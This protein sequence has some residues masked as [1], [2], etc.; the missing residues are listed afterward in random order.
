MAYL[1]V[2]FKFYYHLYY[3]YVFFSIQHDKF[4]VETMLKGKY[5]IRR[6]IEELQAKEYSAT[7]KETSIIVTLNKDLTL[8]PMATKL[9]NKNSVQIIS[10]RNYLT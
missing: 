4:D 6:K 7:Y 2:W 3:Y 8:S 5:E 9:E 10:K 1:F